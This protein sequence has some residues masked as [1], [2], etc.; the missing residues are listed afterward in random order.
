MLMFQFL[1][2]DRGTLN[3]LL[4]RFGIIDEPI[5]FFQNAG[6]FWGIFIGTHIWKQLGWDAIIFV[7]AITGIDPEL[8]EAAAIDGASR[9]QRIW[10]ITLAGIRPTII[11]LFILNIGS[12][13]ATSFDQIM[14]LTQMMGNSFLRERA[15]ILQTYTFRMGIGSMRYSFASA[16]GLINTTINFILLLG[17]NWI[18]RK[19]SETSLF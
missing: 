19:W 1:N 15:D 11:I 7:A 14:M 5:G 2:V 4:M 17:A 8:H 3:E 6:Y 9:L 13:M 10:Y 12:L 18:S 16:V